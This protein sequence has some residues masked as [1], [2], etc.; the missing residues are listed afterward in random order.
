MKAVSGSFKT[1]EEDSQQYLNAWIIDDIEF[2]TLYIRQLQSAAQ[3][4]D[5]ICVVH[6][7][8]SGLFSFGSTGTLPSPSG[9]KWDNKAFVPLP[10]C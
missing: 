7:L 8:L 6:G 3:P 4:A 10:E 5:I 9:L 2:F 1:T